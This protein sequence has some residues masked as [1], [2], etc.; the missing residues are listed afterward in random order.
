MPFTVSNSGFGTPWARMTSVPPSTW[1][2]RS[3]VRM[4]RSD[5]IGLDAGVVHQLAEGGDLLALA[6]GVLGLVDRQP[7]AIAEAGALGDANVGSGGRGHGINS[8]RDTTQ[9]PYRHH[10]NDGGPP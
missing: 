3:A 4:P 8:R 2:A 10:V 6:S 1:S 7:H 5:Q 9:V